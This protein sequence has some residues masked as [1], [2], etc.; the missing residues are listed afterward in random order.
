MGKTN[1]VINLACSLAAKGERVMVLD[2]DLGLGN[3][4]VMLGL[5]P[6]YNL[7]HLFSGEKTLD[8]IIVE[9]PTVSGLFQRLREFRR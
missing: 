5:A 2:A 6:E 1:T 7:K 8:E 3:L 9:G 4:D